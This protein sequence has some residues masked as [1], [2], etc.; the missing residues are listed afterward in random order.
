MANDQLAGGTYDQITK[1]I[2]WEEDLGSIDTYVNGEKTVTIQKD[3]TVKYVY[4]DEEHLSGTI[5]NNIQANLQLTQGDTT[6]LEES[7]QTSCG[8]RVEIPAKVIV[9]HYIYD[10]ETKE[11]TKVQIAE[12]EIINGIIGTEY[13]TSKADV[14]A[15]YTCIIETPEN[16]TGTMTKSDI[17]VTYY[18]E[19][20]DTQIGSVIEKEAQASNSEIAAWYR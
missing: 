12:D 11:Y 5:T 7:K 18:Y 17:E 16:Y 13:V 10:K 6:V 15:D 2:T 3:I 8:T 9:H 14:R 1:T 19:L 20:K 4:E